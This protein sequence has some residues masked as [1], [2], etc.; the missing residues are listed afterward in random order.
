VV[1]ALVEQRFNEN[2]GALSTPITQNRK[3][4]PQPPKIEEKKAKNHFILFNFDKIFIIFQ[5]G[6][7]TINFHLII[8]CPR[9][10]DYHHYHYS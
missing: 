2:W 5:R 1:V 6:T 10:L 3:S 4:P 8:I 9:R 7:T